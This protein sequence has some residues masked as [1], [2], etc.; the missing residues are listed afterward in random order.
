MLLSG[1]VFIM[2]VQIC[3]KSVAYIIVIDKPTC[4]L[5]LFLGNQNIFSDVGNWNGQL[6][7]CL[8]IAL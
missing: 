1:H 7:I 2:V 4:C 3:L 6:D 8:R 5:F